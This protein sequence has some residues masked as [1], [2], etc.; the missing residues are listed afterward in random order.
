MSEKDHKHNS[1]G[2]FLR[3]GIERARCNICL[4]PFD[5]SHVPVQI[6]E[7]GHHF[8]GNCLKKWLQGKGS[9]QGTCPMCRSVLYKAEPRPA[10]RITQ[11]AAPPSLDPFIHFYSQ[12]ENVGQ[13]YDCGFLQDLW[14]AK[15][16][17]LF[18]PSPVRHLSPA[19][20]MIF[21]AF[22]Q[23]RPHDGVH[24]PEATM[25][26]PYISYLKNGGDTRS[27]PLIALSRTL[28]TLAKICGPGMNPSCFLWKVITSF[29]TQPGPPPVFTWHELCNT[30]WDV[31]EYC[32]NKMALPEHRWRVLYLFLIV[33]A[34]YRL[35]RLDSSPVFKITQVRQMLSELD[36][37]FPTDLSY[38]RETAVRLVES[39]AMY[40]LECSAIEG[41]DS[42]DDRAKRLGHF[43][44]DVMQ[45]KAD[46]EA[47]WSEAVHEGEMEIAAGYPDAW[48]AGYAPQTG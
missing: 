3:D 33:M 32:I 30:V 24:Y 40:A 21:I 15:N 37:G 48:W 8:G 14:H 17:I 11:P 46:T 38:S 47:V 10:L 13:S 43:R 16:S 35:Q 41:D 2:S 31:R 20:D 39:A 22:E 6:K 45:L 5:R 36:F 44:T 19:T 28:K 26:L 1:L 29:H 18:L 7:C 23:M 42:R 25:L 9:S 34:L 27:C 12:I 4:A